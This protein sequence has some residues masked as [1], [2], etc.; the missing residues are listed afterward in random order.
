MKAE[1]KPVVIDFISFDGDSDSEDENIEFIYKLKRF[2][3]SFG[4]NIDDHFYFDK[5]SK[6]IKVKTLEGTS[7]DINNTSVI[8]RGIKGEYYPYRK[9]IFYQSYNIINERGN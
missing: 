6:S 4:D 1:K 3:E 9:D 5:N 8:I 2:T 7:Y